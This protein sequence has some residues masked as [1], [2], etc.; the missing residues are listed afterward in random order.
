MQ[1]N[2]YY[3]PT[4]TVKQ[5]TNSNKKLTHLEVVESRVVIRCQV[6]GPRARVVEVRE[7]H[8]VLRADLM[9]DNN[10]IDVIE[11]VPIL[12]VPVHVSEQRLKL[13]APRHGH[14]EGLGCEERLF[15]EQVPVVPGG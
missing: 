12:L 13:G 5:T 4:Q 3:L 11:L 8:P 1:N 9:S 10:F 15:V 7:R 6:D 2:Y 14:V